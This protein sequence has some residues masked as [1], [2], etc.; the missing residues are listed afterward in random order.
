MNIIITFTTNKNSLITA[1]VQLNLNHGGLAFSDFF[2]IMMPTNHKCDWLMKL[3][4]NFWN[5][6]CTQPKMSPRQRLRLMSR[7]VNGFWNSHCTQPK[8]SP[9]Q[10]LRLM[11][12]GVN[13]FWN[14]HCTQPKM[15][16]RHF[17]SHRLTVRTS[18]FHPGNPGSIPGG[19][20]KAKRKTPLLEKW[21][22]SFCL[23]E[24]ILTLARTYFEQREQ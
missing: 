11:S 16:P 7:G 8:M 24:E 6:H 4:G 5:S 21:C 23:C 12:R 2:G 14:S 20:T 22:F 13:G 3:Q 9:R 10:R 18:G 19:I 17:W 1:T 15:S